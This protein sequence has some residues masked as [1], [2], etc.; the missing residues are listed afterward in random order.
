MAPDLEPKVTLPWLVRLRWL[1][2][3][4][5][6]L[7]LAVA[8]WGFDLELSWVPLV[9]VIALTF[10]S[11][12]GLAAV[13]R[14]K[15][16]WPASSTL[17]GV[18]VLDV[19]LLTALLAASGGP[20]NPFT[21][22]YLV[23]ITLSAVVLSARWTASIAIFAVAGFGLLFPLSPT[24]PHAHHHHGQGAL[25][26]HL[27]GMWLAFILAAAL[28]AF[29]VGRIA[30]AI[31]RQ[32]EQ[33]AALRESSVRNAK[34]AALTTLAA[35]AAHE[36]GTP[37][38][39]IAVAAHEAER[40][41][42][43][44][45]NGATLLDDLRLIELEVERCREILGKMAARSAG[46]R[47]ETKPLST[48]DLT[49]RIHAELGTE[50]SQR[51]DVAL[52]SDVPPF[53]V[54]SETLTQCVV[55]LIKNAIDASESEG[56]VVVRTTRG[57]DHVGISIADRGAGIPEGLLEK[58]GEPFFTTKEPGRG[59]GLGVFLART[60]AESQG[61]ALT[62]ESKEGGGTTA[63]LRLPLSPMHA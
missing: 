21:V 25:S 57:D 55:A 16:G 54:P 19:A 46:S 59:L 32:R 33:I 41:A 6:L 62:I 20:M 47:D 18:L 49:H 60:F 17:G 8:R 5:Q 12:V 36:L 43:K 35:G 1:A 29:F 44:L 48:D 61:G 24:D 52:G 2:A 28:T 23:H 58:V 30:Q 45:A 31:G 7:A 22:L 37:L 50:R 34:L 51:V 26:H 14:R 13:I 15:P 4:A 56:T 39:T 38:G 11:N 10:A 40:A 42:A 3:G 53:Q 63:I 27:E 9:I